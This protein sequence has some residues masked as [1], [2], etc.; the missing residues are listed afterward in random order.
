[1]AES[2]GISASGGSLDGI[3]LPR[4]LVMRRRTGSTLIPLPAAKPLDVRPA[5]PAAAPVPGPRGI[6]YAPGHAMARSSFQNAGIAVSAVGVSLLW[7]SAALMDESIRSGHGG[8][9]VPRLF[10]TATI[11]IAV[12]VGARGGRDA[13]NASRMAL[14]PSM[15]VRANPEADKNADTTLSFPHGAFRRT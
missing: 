5:A 8:G 1:M 2:F 7:A 11:C 12:S 13:Y 15:A 9:L 6:E 4:V 3:G 10:S 14:P